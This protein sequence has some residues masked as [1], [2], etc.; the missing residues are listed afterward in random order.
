MFCLAGTLVGI[1][2]H[3]TIFIRGE[4]HLQAPDIFLGHVWLIVCLLLARYYYQA[5]E[6]EHLFQALVLMSLGYI[7]GVL[8]SIAA[9]RLFFHPLSKLGYPGPLMYRISKLWHVWNV[10][11]SN[12]H[13]VMAEL[14]RKYGDFV[15]TGWYQD[16]PA[17]L[18]RLTIRDKALPRSQSL[19]R[20]SSW[21]STVLGQSAP[22]RT[23][24]TSSLLAWLS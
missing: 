19:I 14:H 13:L 15:R 2:V 6:V 3:R 21:P 16:S 4:W 10:R 12:N 7:P 5:S 9:Y 23:G 8:G 20:A 1:A 11:N 24:M 18:M 22:S 17:T